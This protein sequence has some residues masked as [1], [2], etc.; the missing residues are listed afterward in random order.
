MIQQPCWENASSG[1][2]GERQ[3]TNVV[4]KRQPVSNQAGAP[5]TV[6]QGSGGVFLLC[7]HSPRGL[8]RDRRGKQ[9]KL[10]FAGEGES[11][12]PFAE[13]GRLTRKEVLGDEGVSLRTWERGL[14]AWLRLLKTLPGRPCPFP[15]GGHRADC[16]PRGSSRVAFVS[17]CPL[18]PPP[19]P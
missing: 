15:A 6:C 1:T 2:K 16:Q 8:R 9:A 5:A 12:A 7:L 18:R 13:N 10:H 14:S 11:M 3:A 4:V 17:G 19:L